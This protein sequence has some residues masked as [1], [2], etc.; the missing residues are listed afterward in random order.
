M[1]V[2]SLPHCYSQGLV[3]YQPTHGG[4]DV[5]RQRLRRCD[6]QPDGTTLI[7]GRRWPTAVADDEWQA[8]SHRLDHHTPTGFAVAWKHEH[9]RFAVEPFDLVSRPTSVTRDAGGQ[10]ACARK[11]LAGGPLW[12]LADHIEP[13]REVGALGHRPD[14][15]THSLAAHQAPHEKRADRSF[16]SDPVHWGRRRGSQRG[17]GHDLE[18]RKAQSGEFVRHVRRDPDYACGLLVCTAKQWVVCEPQTI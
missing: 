6:R 5:L 13:E 16:S 8:V 18:A 7:C 15:V 1:P 11:G 12:P 17:V 3:H 10:S 9:I 2:C 14:D 4:G